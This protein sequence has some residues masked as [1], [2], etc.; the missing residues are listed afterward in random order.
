MKTLVD[1]VP[2]V[3]CRDLVSLK[4][5]TTDHLGRTVHEACYFEQLLVRQAQVTEELK[6]RERGQKAS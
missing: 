6:R 4:S 2:C 5:A 3:L 1:A